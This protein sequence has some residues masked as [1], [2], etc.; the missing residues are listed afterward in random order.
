MTTVSEISRHRELFANLTLRE[1]RGKYKR[2]VLGWGWSLLNPLAQ[3]AI[4]SLVF[5]FFLKVDPPVGDP[6]GL[7]VFAFFLLCGLLPWTFLANALTGGMGVAAR[8]RQPGE[9]GVVPARAAR[10]RHRR[11]SFGVS[12]LIELGVLAVAAAHRRQH[13]APVAAA[14][15]SV[16]ALVQTVFVLGLALA[17]SVWSVYF[18]DL[19]YLVG[20]VL[21]IWFYATPIVYPVSVVEDALEDHPMLLD[22][23]PAQP[24]GAVRRGLPRPPLLAAVPDARQRSLY[25]V[26]CAG[27]VA[28]RRADGL[29]PPRGPAGGG[30]VSEP[31]IAVDGLS[32][33]FRL[34][35]DRNQTLKAAVMRGRR[36]RY[37]EFWAL[38]DVSLEIAE[39][40]T[41]G[42]IGTNG[43]GKSTLLKCLARILV[44]DEGAVRTRGKVSA[45]LELGA[46]FHPELSGRENVYLNGSI[47]GPV[48][49]RAR[50]PLR[51]HR[52]LRRPRAV[53]RHAGEE[54]LVGHVRAARVLGGHQRRPRHPARRRGA[55]RGRR[56]VPAPLQRA[57]RR[58]A[59]RR[60]RRSWS[61]RT[62][63]ARCRRCATRWPGSTTA[64]CGP[65]ARPATSSTSTSREVHEDRS[66]R[67]ARH[68]VAVGVGRGS[69]RAARG[70]RRATA[71]PPTTSAPARRSPSGFHYDAAEP[72]ERPTFSVE[73]HTIEGVLLTSPSARE[74]R[75][76]PGP[77]SRA[78][79]PSTSSST[80][81]RC[82]PAPTTCRPPSRDETSLH[83]YDSRHRALRFDVEPG[84][85]RESFGGVLV[86]AGP[87]AA[88]ARR[89]QPVAR[90]LLM[91]AL[92][93]KLLVIVLPGPGDAGRH[94]HR[95]RPRARWP[96]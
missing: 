39:G 31:A 68:R 48:E 27:G 30:A 89:L 75:A 42:F 16:V 67:G 78:G 87:L 28:P 95:L 64:G 71:G 60:A 46:G 86:A 66:A 84:D 19:Q 40:A 80:G 5:G 20:I 90:R 85:P 76:D 59:G 92:P 44:P 55:G 73:L 81:C 57:L 74:A 65:S 63:W 29:P 6:S 37:E 14:R 93:G 17:L 2:S 58:P 94:R 4:Y 79:G 18:R 38:R 15:R 45:L 43:S 8:Q 70:A 22:A 52:R 33:R 53:H 69:A 9:E 50:P 88:R 96:T 91:V 25:L 49:A 36:A 24:D 72:I 62:R 3:M 7:H 56:A 26:A 47:L 1:L 11:R 51:R 10:G 82:S 54:L 61:C 12:F 13:G 83:V 21:Q 35:H 34:Y 77:A 41:F 32:K 23:L